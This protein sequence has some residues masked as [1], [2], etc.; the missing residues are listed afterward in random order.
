MSEKAKR[1]DWRGTRLYAHCG[2]AG[3]PWRSRRVGRD[4]QWTE[5]DKGDD[6]WREP[7][8][9]PPCEGTP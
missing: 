7:R 8:Y 9:V 3:C 1:H 6:K 5:Y 4:G 2:N